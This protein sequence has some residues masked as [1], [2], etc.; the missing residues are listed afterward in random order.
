MLFEFGW[1]LMP[2]EAM[3]T[4]PQQQCIGGENQFNWYQVYRIIVSQ[5][6]RTLSAVYM[7]GWQFDSPLP[8]L[9]TSHC[10]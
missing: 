3:E 4:I 7:F 1:K 6:F 5:A 2:S 10:L 8:H 9:R